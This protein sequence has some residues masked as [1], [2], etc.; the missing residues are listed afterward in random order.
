MATISP[1]SRQRLNRNQAYPHKHPCKLTVRI[2]KPSRFKCTVPCDLS[3]LTVGGNV[4]AV[5]PVNH[6]SLSSSSVQGVPSA[7]PSHSQSEPTTSENTAPLSTCAPTP[8]INVQA[9]LNTD[10]TKSTPGL[11][12]VWA[13]ALKIAEKKLSDNKPP[14]DL[15][16]LAS[17]SAG[18]N[19]R[20]VIEALETLQSDE[21]KNRW[22]YTW[23]GKKVII[24][25]HWGKILKAAEPYTK[26]VGTAIQANPQ[27]T[28]LV[29]AGV[30]ALM[31]VC[32]HILSA[33][34]TTGML[35]L[36]QVTLNH[37]DLIEGLEAA[38]A[39]LLEK[40]TI[41][42]FYAGIYVG[43]PLASGSTADSLELKR[44]L[45]SAL[46]DLYAAVIVFVV[47]ARSYFEGKGMRHI[48]HICIDY[49]LLN[50]LQQ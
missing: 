5:P 35:I 25:E 34:E 47:R 18:E 16:N 39:V 2:Q 40:V 22:S 14:L 13:Q 12:V 11:S 17:Q 29:W 27:V 44:L 21:K 1:I 26:V 3:V 31:Q 10:E 20:A 36:W 4:V 37:V 42:E 8:T 24:V 28:A 19:I 6:G 49:M 30:L 32:I 33:H 15:K 23:H 9:L 48:F 45:D 38:I 7:S 46:P 41:C 43:V 50:H